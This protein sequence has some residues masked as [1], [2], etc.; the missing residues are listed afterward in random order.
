[1]IREGKLI[2]RIN[3]L[4]RLITFHIGRSLSSASKRK[5]LCMKNTLSWI[6]ESV[7]DI[8]KYIQY[9]T[10]YIFFIHFTEFYWSVIRVNG[11]LKWTKCYA[12]GE[13]RAVNARGGTTQSVL[14][15]TFISPSSDSG[16]FYPLI[17]TGFKIVAVTFAANDIKRLYYSSM[18]PKNDSF[19]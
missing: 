8:L 19:P 16:T 15:F 4:Y 1:M 18:R 17:Q 2:F 10:F 5:V 12:N 9:I 13:T 7:P 6:I 14:S 11:M 3:I